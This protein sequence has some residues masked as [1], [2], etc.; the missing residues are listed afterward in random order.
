MMKRL[1]KGLLPLVAA[2]AVWVLV[3]A[4]AVRADITDGSGAFTAGIDAVFGSMFQ[5]GS[6]IGF[7]RNADGYDPISPGAPRESYGV[8]AGAVS[9]WAEYAGG[10]NLTPVSSAGGG[11]S[12]ETVVTRL[13]DG[14]GPL[15]E[16]SQTYSFVAANV[17]QIA[18]SITNISGV[19]Q[20]VNFARNV[21]WDI[22]PTAFSEVIHVSPI[23]SPVTASSYYGFESADPLT[24]FIYPA[25][26]GGTFGPGDLG[27]GFQLDLGV[28]AD[29]ADTSFNIYYGLSDFGQTPDALT[30]QVLAY[31][32][33]WGWATGYSD[34]GSFYTA[35]HSI[36]LAIGPAAVPEPS[37]FAVMG[38]SAL[39]LAGYAVRRRSA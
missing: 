39:A 10:Y 7:R 9:G 19:A 17:V 4:Q 33:A 3:P 5:Y 28:L 26:A 13:D 11:L 29:G 36:I 8:S 20:A 30:T 2:A 15:L 32:G 22:D 35:S 23:S 1:G 12:P 21:D 34:D 25:G 27:A 38:I 14:S 6:Y 16:I 37:T 24:P 18:V 31:G